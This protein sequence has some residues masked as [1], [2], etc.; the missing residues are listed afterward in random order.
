M[1]EVIDSPKVL[2]VCVRCKREYKHGGK[3]FCKSCHGTVRKLERFRDAPMIKCICH[4]NCTVIIRAWDKL[5]VPR[6]Y[7]NGHNG[8]HNAGK[9]NGMYKGGLKPRAK[10]YF[11]ILFRGHPNTDSKGY[12]MIHRI[13]YEMYH[14]CCL[15]PWADIHHI[16][17]N[18]KRNHPENLQGMLHS[19]HSIL[20]N[21][22]KKK[23][24]KKN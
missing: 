17:G 2:K 3:G 23:E 15:L 7:A 22:G 19:Q 20:T 10:G 1:T 9:N 11:G 14:K 6:K 21:K 4:P 8:V 16:D 24:K 5:G 18:K 12:I 13:V